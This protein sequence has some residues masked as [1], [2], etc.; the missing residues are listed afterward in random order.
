MASHRLL[1]RAPHSAVGM[2]GQRAFNVMAAATSGRCGEWIKGTP[3]D[4]ARDADRAEQ[5]A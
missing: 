2:V 4:R 3:G 1:R 5:A